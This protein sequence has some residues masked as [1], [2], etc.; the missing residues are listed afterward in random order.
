[1]VKKKRFSIDNYTIIKPK[2]SIEELEE[3]CKCA[4]LLTNAGLLPSLD[5]TP[6]LIREMIN[7][8]EKSK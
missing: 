6:E 2:P 3:L 5:R 8:K 1:M 4:Y 7:E